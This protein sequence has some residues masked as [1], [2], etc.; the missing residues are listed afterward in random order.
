MAIKK[1][2][3]TETAPATASTEELNFDELI[4]QSNFTLPEKVGAI[5]FM[6]LQKQYENHKAQE[7]NRNYRPQPV[8]KLSDFNSKVQEFLKSTGG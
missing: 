6:G 8:M 5:V 2:E 7:Q 1:Q 3:N 4:S